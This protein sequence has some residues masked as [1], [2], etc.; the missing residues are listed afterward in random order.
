MNWTRNIDGSRPPEGTRILVSDGEIQVIAQY[1]SDNNSIT[2][3]FDRHDSKDIEI[4][5]WRELPEL[6]PKINTNTN[7]ESKNSEVN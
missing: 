3:F 4:L 6:P 5:W 1:V 7:Y 2:W